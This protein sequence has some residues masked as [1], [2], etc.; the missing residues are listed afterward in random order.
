MLA[1][2]VRLSG[3][4]DESFAPLSEIPAADRLLVV[5]SPHPIGKEVFC[6]DNSLA[7]KGGM[8]NEFAKSKD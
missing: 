1:K 4:F 6:R 2:A 3:L 7:N 5:Q 8:R